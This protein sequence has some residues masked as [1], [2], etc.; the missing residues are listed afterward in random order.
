MGGGKGIHESVSLEE[1]LFIACPSCSQ[2]LLVS[3]DPALQI[4][5]SPVYL[6]GVDS[7]SLIPL[8][9]RYIDIEE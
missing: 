9:P 2:I 5:L 6:K 8:L 7:I 1:L 4:R 3:L